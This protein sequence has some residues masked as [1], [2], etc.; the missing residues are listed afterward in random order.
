MNDK[1]S[2]GLEAARLD[3]VA[4]AVA[5]IA[6]VVDTV[7]GTLGGVPD[8]GGPSW[9]FIGG[10]WRF[11]GGERLELLEPAGEPGGFLHRFL[12]GRGPGIHH[13]TF[14]I[15]DI[16]RAAAATQEAGFEVIGYRDTHPGW[17]E[18]FIHPK[19]A[20]GI[21]VQ[22]AESHPELDEAWNP[23]WDFPQPSVPVL[24]AAE[25]VGLRM[26]AADVDSTR[27]LWGDFLGGSESE[28]EGLVV[29]RWQDSPLRMAFSVDASVDEG[30][31]ALELRGVEARRLGA[32]HSEA[33]G[34]EFKLL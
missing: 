21:V 3:H 26:A 10:Q 34:T 5:D 28:D 19:E 8:E 12:A 27:R 24:E 22:V 6:S 17:M 2:A 25:L 29:F 13:V 30:P 14:K 9:A 31:L 1:P 18:F 7:A 4:I 15:P 11:A 23:D 32:A 16:A 20:G 33:L